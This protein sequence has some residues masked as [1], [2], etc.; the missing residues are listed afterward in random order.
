M[1]TDGP[2][3]PDC[4][5]EASLAQKIKQALMGKTED[6]QVVAIPDVPTEEELVE[7][8]KPHRSEI[9]EADEWRP[10]AH[11]V[12][13]LILAC[14]KGSR[15]QDNFVFVEQ[16][17]E[18]YGPYKDRMVRILDKDVCSTCRGEFNATSSRYRK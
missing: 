17:V 5:P 10:L 3:P 1:A 9:A 12:R 11:H 18:V 7:A 13:G 6:E 14:I 8:L 4:D 2:T 15:S 16:G